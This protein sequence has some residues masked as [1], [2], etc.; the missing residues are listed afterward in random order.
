M[1]SP[2]LLNPDSL[3][4]TAHLLIPSRLDADEFTLLLNTLGQRTVILL[5]EKDGTLPSTL[6]AQAK[7]YRLIRFEDTLSDLSTDLGV[8]GIAIFLPSQVT[9]L[10]GNPH[11]IQTSSLKTLCKSGLPISPLAVHRT[12]DTKLGID[13]VHEEPSSI[14]KVAEPITAEEATPQSFLRNLLISAED[15]FSSRAFLKR[16]LSSALFNAL[17]HYGDKN[18]VHD[19]IDDVRLTFRRL[20][21]SSLALSDF[22]LKQT[23]NKRI[24]IILPP[25]KG[26]LI[27]NLA[28]LFAGK[29]PVNL[30]FTA[31]KKSIDSAIRQA[32]LDYFITANT[33]MEKMPNFAW[34]ADDQLLKLDEMV[35]KLKPKALAWILK[36]KLSSPAS[37]IKN[38]GL[39]L[40]TDNDEA[41]LLFTSGSS[42]E[43]KGVPLSNRNILA[44]ICQFGS[45]VACEND[46][47]M[48]GWIY[49]SFAPPRP[50]CAVTYVMQT[51]SS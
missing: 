14:I 12:Y 21:V 9:A 39:H 45:R 32:K 18:Y 10:A 27:A 5:T 23:N 28:V 42:G 11:D 1:K 33:F 20:H 8:D 40:C 30:N 4:S 47:T 24:G 44:N 34:P 36:L 25:G 29:T 41:L 2:K 13:S 17:Y 16:S 51:Q 43:P 6:E 38:R 48:L 35:K 7:P 50:S 31:G 37:I 3:L 19:G 46:S 22:I 26:G 15:C 49:H